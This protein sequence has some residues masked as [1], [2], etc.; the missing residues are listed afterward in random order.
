MMGAAGGRAGK[1]RE[2]TVDDLDEGDRLVLL[3]LLEL[4][5]TRLHKVGEAEV[6]L[7]K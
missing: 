7:V 4:H 6:S 5:I 3:P 1:E 2:L